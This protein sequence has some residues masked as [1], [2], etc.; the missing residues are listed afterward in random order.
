L[1]ARSSRR[2]RPA[3]S[4]ATRG[5][6]RL[7]AASG[8]LRHSRRLRYAGSRLVARYSSPSAWAL[9]DAQQPLP[10]PPVTG[11]PPPPAPASPGRAPARGA[12]VTWAGPVVSVAADSVV[13]DTEAPVDGPERSGDGPERTMTP[14]TTALMT[15]APPTI[16]HHAGKRD[17]VG[18]T[19][20]V[21]SVGTRG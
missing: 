2:A 18:T 13:F 10:W 5:A 12:D 7:T 14:I 17:F 3:S 21:A 9:S 20:I 6:L 8:Q 1:G 11:R 16:H 4:P 15:S 19:W